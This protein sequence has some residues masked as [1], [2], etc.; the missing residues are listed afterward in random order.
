MAYRRLRNLGYANEIQRD[1]VFDWVSQE[2]L[3]SRMKEVILQIHIS[4]GQ[5]V[6]HA[7]WDG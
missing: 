1:K 3:D 7:G 5:Y 2:E 6:T 4:R